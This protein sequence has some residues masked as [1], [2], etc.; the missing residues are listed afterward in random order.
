MGSE[1]RRALVDG[2]REAWKTVG[3]RLRET[4]AARREE[5]RRS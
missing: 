1:P 4:D 2:T 3:L 5:R